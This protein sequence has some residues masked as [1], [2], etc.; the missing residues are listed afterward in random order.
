MKAA[1]DE[2][3]PRRGRPAGRRAI[4]AALAFA[5]LTLAGAQPSRAASCDEVVV[6]TWGGDY[7][8]F[9]K[10]FVEPPLDKRG[11]EVLYDVGRPAERKTKLL[12]ERNARTGN[13]D[14]VHLNGPDMYDMQEAGLLEKLDLAKIPNAKNIEPRFAEDYSVPHIYSAETILYNP[15][16]VSPPPDSYAVFLDPKYKGRVG[17]QRHLWVNWFEIGAILE[18]GTPTNYEPG[19]DW[20]KKFKAN[21]PRIYP[22]QEALAVAIKNEEVWLTPNWRARAAMWEREGMPV[23]DVVPKEGA[24]P[25][26]YRAG[27]PKN[28]PHKDCAYAYLDAMLAP[29]A[30]IGFA[31]DM[32][33]I[34]TVSNAE[35]PPDLRARLGFTEAEQKNFF[36]QDYGYI[37][38][39]FAP[40]GEWWD[41]NFLAK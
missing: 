29:Q 31:K 8:K 13:I 23:K 38:K 6:A 30:Q 4:P 18:G 28:A 1:R 12:A 34:P 20:L 27:I 5:A 39:N 9:L 32:G 22:S 35:L 11:I 41:K 15:K 7:E 26:V 37:A 24:V 36:R 25:I 2:S 14:V 40:W 3:I 16:H 19:K 10:Q 17:V 33:Y 21:E